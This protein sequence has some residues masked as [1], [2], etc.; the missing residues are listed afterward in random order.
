MMQH[1]AG[2]RAK[3]VTQPPGRDIILHSGT[4][5]LRQDNTSIRLLGKI[6]LTW[7][8]SPAICFRG[9]TDASERAM[10]ELKAAILEV[11]SKHLQGRALISSW[12]G[13]S[14]AQR[15]YAGAINGSMSART[16]NSAKAIEFHVVNFHK[17]HRPTDPIRHR[18]PTR[19]P[20][21]TESRL[22][23]YH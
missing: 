5:L 1:P 11:P 15:H 22:A 3:Y 4:F 2:H 10:L 9:I 18:L 23:H 14:S 8:P 17:F 13:L 19:A 12:T 21:P 16:P 20:D 6:A 7:F